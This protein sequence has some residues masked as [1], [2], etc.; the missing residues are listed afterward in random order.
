V[1]KRG[2][3]VEYVVG[4]YTRL[5]GSAEPDRDPSVKKFLNDVRF[6]GD[7]ANAF[8]SIQRPSGGAK[9]FWL[10]NLQVVE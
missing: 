6:I 9:Y 10:V 1:L 3:D 8:C 4:E 5:F 2:D 7:Y